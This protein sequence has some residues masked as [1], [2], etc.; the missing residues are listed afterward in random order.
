MTASPCTQ[1]L[2]GSLQKA[3]LQAGRARAFVQDDEVDVH[4][5]QRGAQ[6]D[7]AVC[8]WAVPCSGA[9]P[10]LMGV[11]VQ[12]LTQRGCTGRPR[13]Q[14]VF[15]VSASSTKEPTNLEFVCNRT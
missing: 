13:Q 12:T 1:R 11:P 2:D 6:V 15:S 14:L 5:Q 3:Q 7:D 8:R 4:G 10:V 9:L